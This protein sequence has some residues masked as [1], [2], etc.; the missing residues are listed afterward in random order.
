MKQILLKTGLVLFCYTLII[1]IHL[2]KSKYFLIKESETYPY[3]QRSDRNL[4]IPEKRY[5]SSEKYFNYL[6]TYPALIKNIVISNS[7]EK[8]L[9]FE[10]KNNL[11]ITIFFLMSVTII[12]VSIEIND[13][14]I[15]NKKILLLSIPLL[16]YFFQRFDTSNPIPLTGNNPDTE[17]DFSKIERDIDDLESNQSDLEG[18]VS[19]LEY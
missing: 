1:S 13:K 9:P 10:N 12:I 7:S 4:Y 19:D 11:Y 18:R 3:S 15:V 8:I 6:S 17:S 16:F 2:E 5:V 14:S